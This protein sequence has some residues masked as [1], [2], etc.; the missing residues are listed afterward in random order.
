MLECGTAVAALPVVL[1]NATPTF[2]AVAFPRYNSTYSSGPYL[3]AVKVW[4]YLLVL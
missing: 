2:T 4:A 3:P 1:Y